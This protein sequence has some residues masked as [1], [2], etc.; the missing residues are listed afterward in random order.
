[1]LRTA[2]GSSRKDHAAMRLSAEVIGHSV[3]VLVITWAAR[4]RAPHFEITAA[5]RSAS[6]REAAAC[7]ESSASRITPSRRTFG[8]PLPDHLLGSVRVCPSAPA[9][10]RNGLQPLF[11][12]ARRVIQHAVT[13]AF[14]DFKRFQHSHRCP[15]FFLPISHSS[16]RRLMPEPAMDERVTIQTPASSE[17]NAAVGLGLWPYRSVGNRPF[18]CSLEGVFHNLHRIA[19]TGQPDAGLP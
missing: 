12:C 2:A 16:H 9:E 3:V 18:G 4:S 13:A 8:N 1:V 7:G 17:T 10:R 11:V 5:R 14:G 15:L 6:A 19:R